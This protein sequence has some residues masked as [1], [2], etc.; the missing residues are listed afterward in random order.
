MIDEET[1]IRP[2]H[3]CGRCKSENNP[4]ILYVNNI[5]ICSECVKN[6]TIKGFIKSTGTAIDEKRKL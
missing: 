5:G 2:S 6:G 3:I 4:I 1:E